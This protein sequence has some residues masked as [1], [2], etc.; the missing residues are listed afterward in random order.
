MYEL[1]IKD[2][3]ALGLFESI[4]RCDEQGGFATAPQWVV[5][6]WL[7]KKPAEWMARNYRD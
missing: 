2:S 5:T 7:Y 1:T 3:Y 6:E 4:K